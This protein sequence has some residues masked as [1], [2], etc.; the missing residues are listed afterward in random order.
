MAKVPKATA[1]S[2]MASSALVN[3]E[4]ITP[5][6][7]APASVSTAYELGGVETRRGPTGLRRAKRGQAYTLCVADELIAEHKLVKD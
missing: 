7:L 3:W 5:R 1:R 6:A 2:V 4:L